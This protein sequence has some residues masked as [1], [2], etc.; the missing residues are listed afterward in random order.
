MR[1]I[2]LIEYNTP[3][4]SSYLVAKK[5][6]YTISLGN[7]CKT[8]FKTKTDLDKF[9]RKVNQELNL[10][11]HE[12][13]SNLNRTSTEY[14]KTWFLIDKSNHLNNTN[15]TKDVQKSLNMAVDRCHL[16]NANHYVFNHLRYS[17]EI[18][19]DITKQIIAVRKRKKHTLEVISLQVYLKDITRLLAE[20]KS[21]GK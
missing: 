19:E 17:L 1:E 9:L 5:D 10:I 13:V 3:D 15:F 7:G 20:L 4:K 18:L 21:I 14:Y 11:L 8:S 2:K 16:T 12:T 6:Y